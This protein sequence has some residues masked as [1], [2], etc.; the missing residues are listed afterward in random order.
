M[1]TRKPMRKSLAAT[2]GFT[3]IE[4]MIVVAIIGILA[5]VAIPYF[6]KARNKARFTTCIEAL[7]GV[8]KAEEMYLDDV[9]KYAGNLD[10]LA[11]FFIQGCVALDGSDCAGD[12]QSRVER[13]CDT[14][15]IVLTLQAAGYDYEVT[16]KA[17]D[18]YTCPICMNTRGYLPE[19]Y[20]TCGP[21]YTTAVCP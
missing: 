1:K 4:L 10:Y 7:D 15:T 20:S 17:K 9:G 13:S 11:S 16:A 14:G 2:A 3:L 6:Q 8:R 12:V 5:A 19:Q 18:R 21:T